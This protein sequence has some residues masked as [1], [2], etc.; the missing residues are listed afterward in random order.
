[1]WG[2]WGS[3]CHYG[4]EVLELKAFRAFGFM[5]LRFRENGVKCLGSRGLWVEVLQCKGF[6][7]EG[8]QDL[9]LMVVKF[10]Y[11]KRLGF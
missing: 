10:V 7:L 9:E 3:G 4:A 6:R 2:S 5:W 1:M 8:L 11:L